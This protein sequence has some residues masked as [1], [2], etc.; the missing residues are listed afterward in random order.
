MRVK[1]LLITFLLGILSVAQ[2]QIKIGIIGLDTSHAI[3]FTKFL[4]GADKKEEF[5]DFKIVA[6]YPYGSKTIKSSSDRIPGYIDQVK[7]L[8]VEIVP[9]IEALLKKV[10]CVMLETNDGNMHLEQAL[11]VFKAG[12]IMFID[13]PLGATLAQSIAIYQLAKDYNVPIFSSSALRFVPQNQKLRNGDF[14]KILGADC[15]S[16]ATREITHPDFGWYGIHGVETLFT[17]MGT[18]CI[19]VN[20]MSSEGTDVVV[21][22]WNDGRI[23]TFRGQR[24]GKGIYGGTAFTDKGS[25]QVGPY[26]GYEV[27]L[28][29][30][31]NFFKTR[32]APVS[33]A[34]TLEIFTFM[35]A[36]N[37]SKR[38]EGKIIL[39]E[40]TYRKGLKE[41]RQLLQE[42]KEKK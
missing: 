9:S 35:E 13:K 21:G 19:S 7:E 36:S 23:G 24:T 3:A 22:L 20:R 32:V 41:S 27:L 29:E 17:V 18:G 10:D 11:E 30:I 33:E 34:E 4:N 6:A 25:E 12:K 15:Y 38:K 1:V 8:G 31:L 5:K 2:A 42:L 39:M 16:P 26:Q 37:E 14:G 40:D 28:V